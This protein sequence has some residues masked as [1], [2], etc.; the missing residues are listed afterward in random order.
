MYI[1][2]IEHTTYVGL[3]LVKIYPLSSEK[4]SVIFSGLISKMYWMKSV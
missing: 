4:Q 1:Y 2:L 3:G